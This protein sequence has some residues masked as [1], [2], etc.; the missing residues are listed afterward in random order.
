MLQLIHSL[1]QFTAVQLLLGDDY[2]MSHFTLSLVK[3]HHWLSFRHACFTPC[4]WVTCHEWTHERAHTVRSH[5]T[6]GA[7]SR[8]AGAL[9]PENL[10]TTEKVLLTG[11]L[12]NPANLCW[13]LQPVEG[14]AVRSSNE[15]LN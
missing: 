9:T 2:H 14:I 6:R 11:N 15:K 7:L 10:V 8:S 3:T 1:E 5:R 4:G 13:G 12:I